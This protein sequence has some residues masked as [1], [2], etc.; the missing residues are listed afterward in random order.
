MAADK[1]ICQRHLSY[2]FSSVLKI[3]K[4]R[5][6]AEKYTIK[7]DLDLCVDFL[8]ALVEHSQKRLDSLA[9]S[10]AVS[11]DLNSR[12]THCIQLCH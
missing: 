12:V 3:N 1:N 9:V 5:E 11:N 2:K 7:T 10:R 6:L 8:P 4:L